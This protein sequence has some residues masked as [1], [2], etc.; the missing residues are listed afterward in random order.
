[1]FP[2][3]FF[4]ISFYFFFDDRSMQILQFYITTSIISYLQGVLANELLADCEYEEITEFH[5]LDYYTLLYLDIFYIAHK[6][7]DGVKF[8]VESLRERM[9]SV[10]KYGPVAEED[11]VKENDKSKTD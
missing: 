1:M 3:F 5:T 10:K 4:A 2:K 9:F 6:C 7:F 11:D 8:V